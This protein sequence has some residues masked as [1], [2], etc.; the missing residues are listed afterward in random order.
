MRDESEKRKEALKA[1]GIDVD[2]APNL[3]HE[4]NDEDVLF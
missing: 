3:L 2:A 1:S 4:E